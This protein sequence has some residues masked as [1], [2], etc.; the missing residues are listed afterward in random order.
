M[1]LFENESAMQK[2][3]HEKFESETSLSELIINYHEFKDASLPSSGSLILKKLRESYLFCMSSFENNELLFA[4]KNISLNLKD[5]LKPDFVL[6]AAE[7]Q[8]IVIV[9]LK[10]IKGPTRQV[11]TELGAYAA[12]VKS[13][14]PYLADGEVIN[15]IISTEWPVL[16]RHYVVN[17][18]MWLNRNVICLEPVEDEGMILLRIVPPSAIAD[19]DKPFSISGQ[20]LGGYHLCL[21]DYEAKSQGN[22]L[23]WKI[24]KIRS[25]QP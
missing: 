12:E 11:G 15:V 9:E 18:I 19:V 5:V 7:T 13:Y 8:S 1:K 6:Y 4:N 3:L 25:A 23:G 10:N 16:L 21:Y 14:L 20:Q 2:W 24:M 22:Y 17:E